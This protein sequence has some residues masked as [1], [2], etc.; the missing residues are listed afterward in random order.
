MIEM[1]NTTDWYRTSKQYG[2]D[3][4]MN[5]FFCASMRWL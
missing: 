3:E 5:C 2:L 4:K 1:R